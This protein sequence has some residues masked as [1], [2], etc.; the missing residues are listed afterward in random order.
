MKKTI[1]EM[2]QALIDNKEAIIKSQ[3]EF[4]ST[5]PEKSR[6]R[7]S[8]NKS[9]NAGWCVPGIAAWTKAVKAAG[10]PWNHYWSGSAPTPSTQ[11]PK[12]IA[13]FLFQFTA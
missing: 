12:A 1:A 4:E 10:L 7:I 13:D 11:Y 8:R 6:L 3:R 5:L 9:C 2:T